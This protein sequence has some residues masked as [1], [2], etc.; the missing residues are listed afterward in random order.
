MVLFPYA[1]IN[2]GLQVVEKRHDGFHN[3][4]S[5]LY[6]IGWSDVLEILEADELSFRSTGLAIP[7]DASSNLCLQ[8][9]QL[10][11]ESYNISPVYIHLHKVVPIGAGLGG[12][13]SDAAFTLKGLNQ[14]FDLSLSGQELKK[15]AAKIG[16]DCAFFVDGKPALA[17]GKGDQLEEINIPDPGKYLVVVTPP[18]Q[19]NTGEAYGMINPKPAENNLAK[20]LS[21]DPSGWQQL[22]VNDFEV[23]VFK[24]YPA[25]ADIK[26]SLME[27]GAIYASMS[28]SGS[29]VFGIFKEE[30]DFKS[31]FG[32]DYKIWMQR[33]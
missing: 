18:V 6:P 30:F 28:G 7:G 5:G 12:G 9:Y 4:I 23:A 8:A 10:I 19:V 29:S 17:T 26:T 15:L 14:L 2:L 13:S 22:I 20:A 1:K 27:K 33:T 24:R 21:E 31:W 32:L 11:K 25:I 16:S 3:I